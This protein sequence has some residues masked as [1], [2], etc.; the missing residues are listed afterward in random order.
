MGILGHPGDVHHWRC[1][2]HLKWWADQVHPAPCSV[3]TLQ[4]EAWADKDMPDSLACRLAC[5]YC[6][7][8]TMWCQPHGFSKRCHEGLARLPR[9]GMLSRTLHDRDERQNL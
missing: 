6:A 7:R 2:L 4:D 1:C 8:E 5:A 3:W 9:W